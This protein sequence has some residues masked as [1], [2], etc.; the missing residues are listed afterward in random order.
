MLAQSNSNL[1]SQIFK[2]LA[3]TPE[4]TSFNTPAGQLPHHKSYQARGIEVQGFVII[5]EAFDECSPSEKIKINMI[6]NG[7]FR[8]QPAHPNVFTEVSLQEATRDGDDI[9]KDIHT[10]H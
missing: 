4:M 3:S 1:R 5:M 9:R 10:Y 6:L 2:A 8:D 7:A